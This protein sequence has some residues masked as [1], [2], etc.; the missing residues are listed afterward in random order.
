[1]TSISEIKDR[2]EAVAFA[3]RSYPGATRSDLESAYK[4]ALEDITEHAVGDLEFLFR[5][6][7][8]L[9]AAITVAAMDLADAAGDI[10][11]NYAANDDEAAEIRLIIGE[12]MDKLINVAQGTSVQPEEEAK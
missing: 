4:K 3:G 6:L 1:M 2:L 7:G 5:R 10:A 12:P 8:E 9:R 11:A